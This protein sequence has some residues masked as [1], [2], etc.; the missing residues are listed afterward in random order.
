M[1]GPATVSDASA[2]SRGSDAGLGRR[3]RK[4]GTHENRPY[5]VFGAEGERDQ[6]PEV[7]AGV[8]NDNAL[9]RRLGIVGPEV[10]WIL[11]HRAVAT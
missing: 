9:G 10:V 3:R 4:G 7:G 8:S 2:R 1:P 11:G 5:E 6:S